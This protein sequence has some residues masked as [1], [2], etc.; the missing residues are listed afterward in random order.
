MLLYIVLQSNRRGLESRDMPSQ[1]QNKS[2][3]MESRDVSRYRR[4]KNREHPRLTETK[5]VDID[6]ITPGIKKINLGT[7]RKDVLP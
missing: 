2:V 7:F 5:T 6:Y 1:D 4:L 3:S